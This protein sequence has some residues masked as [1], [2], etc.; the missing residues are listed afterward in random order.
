MSVGSVSRKEL[1]EDGDPL[2]VKRTVS[3]PSPEPR[4][5]GGEKEPETL[6]HVCPWTL[7]PTAGLLVRF[8]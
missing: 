7:S 4:G 2:S 6:V 1:M 3:T 5:P 8:G